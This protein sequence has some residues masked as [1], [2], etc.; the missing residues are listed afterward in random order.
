MVLKQPTAAQ[1]KEVLKKNPQGLS[2]TDIVRE[3]HVNRNT[4]GR[5]LEKL[6]ISGQVEM[7]HFG[8]AK[9]YALANRV[10]VSAVLSISSELILQLDSSTRIVF[11]NDAFARFLATP[12]NDLAGKNIE[13]SPLVTAFDDLF[14]GFLA[15]VKTG[16]EG[17]EWRGEIGPV[18]DGTIFSCRIAPTALDH[19]QKGVSV[20]LE[21]ITASKKAEELLHESEEQYRML[22]EISRDLIFLVGRDD[23]VEY[24]NSYAAAILGKTPAE[25]TGQ[26]R[27]F[28]FPPETA[29]RQEMSLQEVFFSGRSSHSEGPLAVK[30]EMRWFDHM[31]VPLKNPDGSVRA[32]LGVSRDITERRQS[33]EKL[34]S[35]EERYRRLLQRSFDAVVIHK[36]GIITLANQA[37]AGLAGASSP[38]D[39]VG[40]NIID[41]VHPKYLD[42]VRERVAAMTSRNEPMAVN[43]AEEQFIRL[44]GKAITVEVV[45]T[46]FHDNGEP[47]IQVVFRDIT[48]R[49]ELVDALR[50]SEE[51]Y[52]ILIE[53]SQSGV[54][55]IRKRQILYVNTAF[56]RILGGVPADFILQDFGDF[57]AP[58]DR[59]RVLALGHR[60][61]KGEKVTE[62]YECV[63]LKRDGVT[64]VIVSLDAGVV[65]YEGEPASM[66]TIRDITEKKETELQLRESEQK[67][68]EFADFLPQSVWECDLSGTLIF[69]NRGSFSMYRYSPDD[70]EGSLTIWQMISPGDRPIISAWVTRALSKPIEEFP[71]TVEYT[72]L[73]KDGSTFPVKTF[74]T[75]VISNGVI[76]GMRGI[77]IDM[78]DQK[79]AEEALRE[80]GEKIRA[81]FDSTFQ[82]TGIMNPDGTLTDVNHTALEFAGLRGEDVINRPFWETAW[83]QGDMARVQRLKEAVARAA[84]GTFVRYETELQGT[85]NTTMFVDF[86]IKPVFDQKGNV[87]TLITEARDV[88]KSKHM[89]DA[90]RE[91]EDR[92][93]RMFEDGPLGMAIVGRDYRFVLVNRML[94]EMMGYTEQELLARSF[95]DITHPDHLE[96]DVTE[97]EKLY[98]GEIARYRTEKRYIRK[99]GSVL[100][101]ALTVSPLRD[102]EG[103]IVSTL[104][105]IEDITKWK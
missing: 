71:A 32:V 39:L 14:P 78:T 73:R 70:F 84:K 61:Q 31:L 4:A 25:V 28:L 85:G 54:F 83:W 37:A 66:G 8:M 92:F 13:Y 74:V 24:V 100:W 81:I 91:S 56:A 98:T 48:R 86:S 29:R 6:L 75:P 41:F 35:S 10:P 46:S 15:R 94:C 19:G 57:I 68:R 20:I 67:F 69:A 30:G 88:T 87:R 1:I 90:L 103:H 26:A 105:L 96:Q 23:R 63:L 2:I 43:M 11:I 5:Y 33:E 40:K 49:K 44:D 52:R 21:D 104:S 50:Q 82:F 45:A 12:A 79:R 76:T 16:L 51:K 53:H 22:A 42:S 60:R 3:V 97:V 7:R 55:I 62:T 89:E 59:E 17:T 58:E 27:S 64:R 34:R 101:G 47:A 18:R 38:A 99:D 77:G 72:A 9:I 36:N 65:R 80:S 102:R 93:R 95:T